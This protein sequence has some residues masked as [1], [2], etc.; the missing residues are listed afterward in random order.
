MESL[1]NNLISGVEFVSWPLFLGGT[2]AIFA[3]ALVQGATGLGFGM[4]AAP[5]L[6]IINPIFVPGPLLVLAM[7]VS[8]LI[9]L[10]EWRAIDW[11]GLSVATGGRIVGTL[12]AG[13]TIAVI[14]LSVYG[15][16][17]GF[18]VLIAVLLSAQGWKVM[19]SSRN[20]AVAGV[21]SGYMGTLTSI[22]A[23]PMAL[24]YQNK[25]GPVIRSTL[26]MFFVIGAAISVA[27]LIFV[28]NFSPDQFFI[29]LAFL[30]ALLIGFWVSG[31]MVP[32]VKGRFVRYSVL[33]LSALTSLI[34]VIKS[35]VM[36]I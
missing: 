22:G 23:P 15:L 10:R 30:P 13:F 14:P 32:R 17:F 28:G 35:I 7:L 16:I 1:I 18:M 24:A 20:L 29:S 25:A 5:I 26:A 8:C 6:M 3:G 36:M 33:S 4:I 12:L 34:L 31:W 9:A 2:L 21:A 19:P 11:G 27:T